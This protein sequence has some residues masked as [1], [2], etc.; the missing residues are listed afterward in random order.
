MKKKIFSLFLIFIMIMSLIPIVQVKDSDASV[1]VGINKKSVVLF[2]NQKYQLKLSGTKLKGVVSS[3]KK[4]VVVNNKGLIKGVKAGK[5][6]ISL[7]GSN[8]KI[9]KCSVTVKNPYISKTSI[10]LIKGKNYTLKLYG[11]SIKSVATS[12]KK[13]ATISKNGVVKG[14]EKGS[15][16]VYIKGIDNKVYKC[17]V[18]V[19]T[20]SNNKTSI[21]LKKGENYT[22]K[23]QGNA[24][25]KAASTNKNIAT[26]EKNGLIKTINPGVCFIYVIDKN[27]KV[28][29]YTITVLNSTNNNNANN[30][31]LSN[32]ILTLEQNKTFKLKLI[33]TDEKPVWSSE[34]PET[35][36]ISEDGII[37]AVYPGKT[38]IIATLNN[39]KY[40]CSVT[41]PNKKDI[42]SK[43]QHN[44]V[45][46]HIRQRNHKY[47]YGYLYECNKCKLKKLEFVGTPLPHSYYFAYTIKPT[48]ESEGYDVYLCRY[49]CSKETSSIKKNFTPKVD[50]EWILIQE[51]ED[52][53]GNKFL[54][55]KCKYC[56][57]QN[58][59]KK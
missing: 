36:K 6:I 7:K 42:D 8:G 32:T 11:T 59:I 22:I 34:S 31:Y 12:N 30:I 58:T 17:K 39:Q 16:Y 47:P 10:S 23:L 40:Y 3:N 18:T 54:D 9:Y 57:K 29:N 4:V 41:V 37:T 14:I 50:H 28:Y 35:A 49:D 44:W 1:R 33:G 56:G 24:I 27:N 52:S 13:I 5:A 21:T 46:I 48:C 53:D 26:V 43:C 38:N 45:L 25:K 55:Y 15:C 19:K 20:P 51:L 2:V